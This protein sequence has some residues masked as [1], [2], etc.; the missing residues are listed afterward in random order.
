MTKD[1]IK[2]GIAE[3]AEAQQAILAEIAKHDGALTRHQFD[4]VFGAARKQFPLTGR[5]DETIILGALV[6]S[7]W[8]QWLH[9]AQLMAVAGIL[10]VKMENGALV[11]RKVN[12]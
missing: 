11:Y 1:E 6:C 3:Y 4:W 12:Q 7:D 8:S 10:T 2:L 9:L 5:S